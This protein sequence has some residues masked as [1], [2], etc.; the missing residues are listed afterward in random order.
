MV[1]QPYSNTNIIFPSI[2]RSYDQLGRVAVH[3]STDINLS[4]QLPPPF[5]GVQ[6][7][8][9]FKRLVRPIYLLPS[10]PQISL[11]CLLYTQR[12]NPHYMT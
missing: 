11:L 7:T 3:L 6:V 1:K 8:G 12:L 9:S 2:L 4:E 10:D 5:Y